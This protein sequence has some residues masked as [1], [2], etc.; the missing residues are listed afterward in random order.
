[1]MF[2]KYQIINS[3]NKLILLIP[4]K[5]TGGQADIVI[6]GLSLPWCDP[7]CGLGQGFV[8]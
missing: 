7:L 8:I 6:C 1:M 4:A 5:Q 2:E 3:K